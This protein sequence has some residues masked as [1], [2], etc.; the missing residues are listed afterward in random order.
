M[1]ISGIDLIQAKQ[2]ALEG[3]E[4]HTD[5]EICCRGDLGLNASPLAVYD[6]ELIL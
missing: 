3:L 4:V 1:M 2:L 6:E 5:P